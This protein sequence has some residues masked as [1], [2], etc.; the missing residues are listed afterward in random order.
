MT[1]QTNAGFDAVAGSAAYGIATLVEAQARSGT[2]RLTDWP[3]DLTALGN[4]WRGIGALGQVG[5]LREADDGGAQEL[6]MSLSPIDLGIRGFALGEASDYQDRPIRLWICM[7]DA[8]TFQPAGAPVMRF[9]G[10]MDVMK[11]PR[12]DETRTISMEMTCRVASYDVRSNPSALRMNDAQHRA[13]YPDELGF[14][15]LQS[16]IGNP[17]IYT[18]RAFGAY[19][20]IRA[21]LGL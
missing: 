6:T 12:D 3:V 19:L 11:F 5:E 17:A 7:I 1:V 13:K 9:G 20:R 14:Q 8:Q 15:Y 21:M 10:V 2:L 4:T 16:L 18:S